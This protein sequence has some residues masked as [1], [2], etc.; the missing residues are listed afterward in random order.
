[1]NYYFEKFIDKL[2]NDNRISRYDGRSYENRRK[3]Y[4][5]GREYEEKELVITYLIDKGDIFRHT[6]A[7]SI[8]YIVEINLCKVVVHYSDTQ[9]IFFGLD[10]NRITGI[11]IE[12]I[13]KEIGIKYK[14][15]VI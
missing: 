8:I 12:T 5:S 1:M 11:I 13:N 10:Y 3:V 9:K 6:V 15:L 4:I 2:N 7:I 14:K